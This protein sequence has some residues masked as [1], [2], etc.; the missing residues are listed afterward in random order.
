MRSVS[1]LSPREQ[2]GLWACRLAALVAAV[3]L[4]PTHH[5]VLAAAV[6]VPASIV[7]GG[8]GAEV[9]RRRHGRAA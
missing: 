3:L 8:V 5:A 2:A 1:T 6:G 7:V 4:V 9:L